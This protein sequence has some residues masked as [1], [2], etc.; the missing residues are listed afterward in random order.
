MKVFVPI[1]E[2]LAKLQPTCQHVWFQ[3]TGDGDLCARC[4]ITRA[5]YTDKYA[6]VQ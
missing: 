2:Q 1:R 3:P 4:H 6:E 5:E